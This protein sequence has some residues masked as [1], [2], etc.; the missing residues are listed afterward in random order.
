[1]GKE[2]EHPIHHMI[3]GAA[4]G[5]IA[6]SCMHPIDTIRAR[7]QVQRGSTGLY[8]GTIH[9]LISIIQQEGWTT[10][11]KGYPIV[12]SAT[13]PAH[14]LYFVGYELSKKY[15]GKLNQNGKVP[16]AVIHFSSGFIADLFGSIV[17]T[18]MDV[19]KQRLQVQNINSQTT[20]KYSGSFNALKTIIKEEGVTGL[21]RGIVPALA[22]YGPL[23]GIYFASYEQIKKSFTNTFK[24]K[25]I[26]ELPFYLHLVSGGLAGSFAAAVTCPLDVV[27]T[28]I[29]VQSRGTERYYKNTLHAFSTIFR[30]EGLRAFTKGMS[31]RILWIAPGNAITIAAYEHCKKFAKFLYS[32]DK[33]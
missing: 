33:T 17:W 9:A 15:L 22:T 29:Q 28:R 16:D 13:I 20:K 32:V 11:Y 2:N 27:K 31:A 18:P 25:D 10:L 26:H 12:V 19:I 21:Y 3:A 23:V 8:K 1:M 6:D 30:E 4:A 7:M 24:Y 14:A 5:V